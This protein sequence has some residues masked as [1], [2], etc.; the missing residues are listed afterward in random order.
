MATLRQGVNMVAWMR[1]LAAGTA[2][3]MANTVVFVELNEGVATGPS[4]MAL[5]AARHAAHTMGSSVYA[6]VAS[7]ALSPEALG[8]LETQAGA[9]GADKLLFCA[10]PALAGPDATA[11]IAALCRMV[12]DRL[13]PALFLFPNQPNGPDLAKALA[14]ATGKTFLNSVKP[15]AA[16]DAVVLGGAV[17]ATIADGAAR[18]ALGGSPAEVEILSPPGWAQSGGATPF[19]SP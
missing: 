10:D 12:A 3:T 9:G 16:I 8:A 6:L 2:T 17:V 5:A 7:E 11:K 13:R 18:P 14:G 15:Q 19:L 4:L 1:A